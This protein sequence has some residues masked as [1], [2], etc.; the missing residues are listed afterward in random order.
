MI[1]QREIADPPGGNTD[2]KVV[3]GAHRASCRQC[4]LPSENQQT[5]IPSAH[6]LKRE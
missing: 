5:E 1:Y 2:R 6:H 4:S 3:P